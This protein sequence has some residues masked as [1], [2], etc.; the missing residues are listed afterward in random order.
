[1]KYIA[2]VSF[3]K[4]SLAMLLLLIEKKYPLDEI[5]F[6]DTGMEFD[7]IYRVREQVRLMVDIPIT[8]LK[9]K[10]PFLEKMC[11]KPVNKRDGTIQQGYHWC[12]GKCRWGT[13]DKLNTIDS[14]TKDAMVYIGIA[15]DEP[16]RIAKERKPNKL[17]PLVEWGITEAECLKV[18]R[19]AGFAWREGNVDLYDILKRVSCWCC[20]NKNLSELRNYR[21]YLP[22]YWDRLKA[23]QADIDRPF[24]KDYDVFKRLDNEKGK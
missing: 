2:S 23:L 8:T 13:T 24:R 5:I 3:G 15:A 12:G 18:C 14:L 7:C 9:P 21:D 19:D 22:E 20:G 10:I 1:M 11:I 16:K 17:M 4:D 6:Y